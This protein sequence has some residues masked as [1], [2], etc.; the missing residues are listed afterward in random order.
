M[1]YRSYN[2][3]GNRGSSYYGT[4]RTNTSPAIVTPSRPV[5]QTVT[6][7][8][9]SRVNSNNPK[10][11]NNVRGGQTTVPIMN[12]YSSATAPTI[13]PGSSSS[14]ISTA[15]KY[16]YPATEVRNTNVVSAGTNQV[17]GELVTNDPVIRNVGDSMS[18]PS[19]LEG[20]GPGNLAIT[21]DIA[22][23]NAAKRQETSNQ[24]VIEQIKSFQSAQKEREEGYLKSGGVCHVNELKKLRDRLGT[25]DSP[26]FKA[27]LGSE[28]YD[29]DVMKSA[30]CT[31][32]SITY[33]PP[34]EPGNVASNVRIKRWLHN[35]HRIG[36]ESVEGFAMR[37]DLA[38]A[39]DTFV[40]KAPRDPSNPVLL[41]EYFVGVYGLNKI[42]R[43]VPN[44]AYIMGGFR[45]SLPVIDEEKRVVAW[46][47]NQNYPIDYVIYE[48]IS[49]GMTLS[50]FITGPSTGTRQVTDANGQRY[51]ERTYDPKQGCKFAD[52]LNYYM[53][54]LYA[55]KIAH[56]EVDYTHYD[57]H[58]ENVIIRE[59]PQGSDGAKF[60]IPYQT[61]RNEKEY[62]V[63]NKVATV[64]DYGLSHIKYEG[65]HFGVADRVPWGVQPNR[66]FPMHDAYK[67]LMMSL[68]DMK[69]ADNMECFNRAANILQFF[70]NS[71]S[72]LDVVNKQRYPY[73]YYLP[74]N[75]RTANLTFDDLTAYIR[76]TFET[77]TIV[78]N[79][80]SAPVLGCEGN[81][82]C[83]N[84]KEFL[85]ETGLENVPRARNV[86]DYYDLATRLKAENRMNDYQDLKAK[87]DWT[88]AKRRGVGNY[89]HTVEKVTALLDGGSY[90]KPSDRNTTNALVIQQIYTNN[91]QPINILF[92]PTT[93]D[94][95]K[96]FIYRV[97]EI[98]DTMQEGATLR[99][100]LVYTAQDFND[101]Q[102]AR[103]VQNSYELLKTKLAERWPSIIE[104]INR[105]VNHLRLLLSD[106]NYAQIINNEIAKDPTYIWWWK[107]LP[108]IVQVV[109][110]PI[111]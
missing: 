94:A 106:A 17:V 92:S 67:L 34:N 60:A 26:R 74:Y 111:Y 102:I 22:A 5:V 105:D 73:F 49:P 82:I 54:I 62:I 79:R 78:T 30:M 90:G 70:N 27:I 8:R 72:A 24:A 75:D 104:S 52:W 2:S 16:N 89:N 83:I 61:E 20:R 31:T 45:C 29:P 44:F 12:R 3:I 36:A 6:A 101:E 97:A 58:T 38:K 76:N 87:F 77:E 9:S 57:L 25:F 103:D 108:E 85:S 51:L 88:K 33:T 28:F 10:R 68:N 35:L 56:R 71:E 1:S 46:C 11:F 100:A 41:H 43:F 21:S 86:F 110:E 53:Q 32:E 50:E 99:N 96:K 63:T 64:I 66:S 109:D 4:S 65:E 39:N 40:I 98:Y 13:V 80:P 42:R 91:L 95:Y 84:S 47:N 14:T 69:R 55:L 59:V 37:S 93:L 15:D 81:D 23:D 7:Y 18:A 48:N 19:Q 107:F